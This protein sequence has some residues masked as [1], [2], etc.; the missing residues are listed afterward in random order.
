[1]LEITTITATC[2]SIDMLAKT[3]PSL[4]IKILRGHMT[5]FIRQVHEA[6]LRMNLIDDS[7]DSR[8]FTCTNHKLLLPVSDRVVL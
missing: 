8:P 4:S 3:T 7:H 5:A 2:I 1:M 6:V